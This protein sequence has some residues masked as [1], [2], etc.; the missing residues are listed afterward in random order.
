MGEVGSRA[1]QLVVGSGG[2]SACS[3][4][5][6]CVS[7]LSSP[8]EKAHVTPPV[9]SQFCVPS[10]RTLEQESS[11]PS[12]QLTREEMIRE[13]ERQRVERE[14]EEHVPAPASQVVVT[15]PTH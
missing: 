13:R 2:S 14:R 9:L 5:H 10:L 15:M 6:V 12:F 1:G 7:F 11:F 8:P 4:M 3:A